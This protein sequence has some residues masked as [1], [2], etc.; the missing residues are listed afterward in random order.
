MTDNRRDFLK[1]SLLAGLAGISGKVISK[2]AVEKAEAFSTL[3][4]GPAFVLPPLPYGYDALEPFIDRQTME[5][6]HKKHHQAY[7]DKLN[8]VPPSEIKM[9]VTD[10]EKCMNI[11]AT[12]STL[13]RNN[14]G[15]YYNHSLFW[16]LMRPA[17]SNNAPSGKLAE[18][19]NAQF[20]SIE[21]FKKELTDKAMKIFGSGWCWLIVD[22]NKKLKITTTPNQDNPLMKVVPENGT[23]VLTLDVWEHAYYLKY[24]NKRADYITAWWNVVNWERAGELFSHAQK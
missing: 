24:Q 10:E 5:I 20:K 7:I 16:T 14:L 17:T 23:P 19:L 3:I 1:K 9:N 13:L 22:A 12:S 18:A 8:T 2:D 6:H 15:G 11:T 21:D 4:D